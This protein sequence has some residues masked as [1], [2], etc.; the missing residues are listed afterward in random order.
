METRR[1]PL[2]E[3]LAAL[4]L[5]MSSIGAELTVGPEELMGEGRTFGAGRCSTQSSG[6]S[7]RVECSLY[8]F[9]GRDAPAR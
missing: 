1:L 2:D 7:A 6:P 3:Q 8:A 4:P 5:P 9:R